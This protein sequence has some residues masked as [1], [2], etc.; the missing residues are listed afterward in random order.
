MKTHTEIHM[1]QAVPA[2]EGGGGGLLASPLLLV[3]AMGLFMYALL[4]RP[5]QRRDK[6][7]KQMLAQIEK[8]DRV[9]TSGG[10]HGKVVG[11]ADDVLTVEIADRV[12]VKLN[13][14]AVASRTARSSGKK[15]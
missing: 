2:P 4:I 6:E 11:S 1:A 3:A 12:Q 8:G 10:L 5:Q 9:I 13:K 15:P 14:S 7:H